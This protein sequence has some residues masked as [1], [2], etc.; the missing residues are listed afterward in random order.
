MLTIY[1][2]SH[3]AAGIR[4]HLPGVRAPV[5]QKQEKVIFLDRS[6]SLKTSLNVGCY[7]PSSARAFGGQ[8]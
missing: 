5:N 4:E 2:L 7:K 3:P 8:T 1:N 6:V